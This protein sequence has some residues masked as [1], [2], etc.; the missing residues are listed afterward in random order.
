MIDKYEFG[1]IAID[2]KSYN[3]DVIIFPDK[4][5]SEWWRKES[6]VLCLEDLETVFLKKPKTLIIGTGHDGVMKVLPEVREYC[7]ENGIELIEQKTGEAVKTFNKV[8]L[9][10]GLIAGFHLTC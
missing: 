8:H 2:G 3:H 5:Q 7:K 10:N 4:V 6:H 1:H 9:E